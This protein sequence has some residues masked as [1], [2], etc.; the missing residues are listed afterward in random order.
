MTKREIHHRLKYFKTMHNI[1]KKC[2]SCTNCGHFKNASKVI[3]YIYDLYN[4]KF[5]RDKTRFFGESTPEEK[6]EF[7]EML[8]QQIL[9]NWKDHK[10]YC[11]RFK[12][13]KQIMSK[14]RCANQ[15]EG[16]FVCDGY[17]PSIKE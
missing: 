1:D 2:L 8:F 17:R 9:S 6:N 7:K 13:D 4:S 15:V 11:T 16:Q 3:G 12:K 5:P 10:I 14:P